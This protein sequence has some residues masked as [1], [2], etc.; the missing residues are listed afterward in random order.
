M[1]RDSA[2]NAVAYARKLLDE[3]YPVLVGVN[4][5]DHGPSPRNH[6]EITDHFMVLHGYETNTAGE[7]TRFYGID[8]AVSGTVEMTFEV[9]PTT[10][11]IYRNVDTNMPSSY[12]QQAYQ[13]DQVRVWRGVAPDD[14]AGVGALIKR[15][16][17]P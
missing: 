1:D 17:C 10:F 2:Q 5:S 8:N 13:V 9:D 12:T 7:V 4:T 15:R 3:G 6:G 14:E 16:D 11:K